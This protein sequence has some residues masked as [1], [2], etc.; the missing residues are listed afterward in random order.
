MVPA[1]RKGGKE[2][3][4]PCHHSLE[5]YHIAAEGI[6]GEPDAPLFQT[7]AGQTGTLTQK[8]MG[9]QDAYRMIERWTRRTVIKTRIGN[10]TFRAI[11]ITAYLKNEGTLEAAQHIANHECPRTTK[12]DDRG[13]DEIC[14]MKWSA[15][16][17]R[18]SPRPV[19]FPYTGSIITRRPTIAAARCRLPRVMSFFGSRIRST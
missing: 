8:A 10:H 18:L 14:S 15:L 3:E 6:A 11:G 4:V 5:Q 16:R 17:F 9:Q 2:H 13:Q 7:A 19:P 1:A 12:L